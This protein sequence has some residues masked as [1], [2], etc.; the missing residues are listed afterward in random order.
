MVVWLLLESN[1]HNTDLEKLES[2]LLFSCSKHVLEDFRLENPPLTLASTMPPTNPAWL[3]CCTPLHGLK[4]ANIS[5]K[6]LAD[7]TR[8]G[9]LSTS[10]DSSR[11][12]R[13][14]LQ[15]RLHFC[16][17]RGAAGEFGPQWLKIGS[18]H[19]LLIL[20]AHFVLWG[21]WGLHA[22]RM[23][24]VW[25]AMTLLKPLQSLSAQIPASQSVS[26]SLEGVL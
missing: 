13:P 8:A 12:G 1:S 25:C 3:C 23:K 20:A 4:R 10:T 22:L 19:C 11:T 15:S 24:K 9:R 5:E 6:V 2:G 21:L 7:W 14:E 26:Q 16:S 18:G 17:C